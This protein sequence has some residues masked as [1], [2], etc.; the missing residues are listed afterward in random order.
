MSEYI[1]LYQVTGA[2][3]ALVAASF[4]YSLGGRS[5]KWRRRFIASFIL[6]STVNV[7]CFLRGHW[8][9][10][11]IFVY[12]IL[13][14]GFCLGYGAKKIGS[15]ILKRLICASAVISAGVLLAFLIGGHAWDVLIPHVGVGLWS[16]YLGVRNP[17]EAPA[18]EFF[19]CLL[20]NIGLMMCS[21]V[22]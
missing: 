17:V 18:E 13:A 12:P 15:K 7:I 3:A 21:F 2:G 8:T 4:F 11:M 20:L 14:G 6:A 1:T 22:V 5:G 19:I 10:W 16:V 9:P